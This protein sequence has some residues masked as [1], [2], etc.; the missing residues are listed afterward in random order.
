MSNANNILAYVA[1]KYDG[2]WHKMYDHIKNKVPLEEE[3]VDEYVTEHVSTKF[4]TIVDENYPASLK[5]KV[6]KPPF[7]LFYK[8]D[9]S[10]LNDKSY[11]KLSVVGSRKASRYGVSAVEKIISELSS[12]FIV[13]SGLATGIDAAAHKAALKN[14][15]KTI[16]VLGSGIDNVY[17][18]SNLSLYND[19]LANGGLIVSEYPNKVSPKK[20]NFVFRNRIVAAFGQFLL[21]G[22]AYERSGTQTTLNYALQCGNSVGCVPYSIFANSVC[23]NYIKDGAYLIDGG[24]EIIEIMKGENSSY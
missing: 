20:E 4:M 11:K 22:E 13:I 17:P 14:G 18:E 1:L 16:A 24:K 15:L 7:V 9:I 10:L 23:N 21:I 3:N 8:G 5:R 12:D 2:D 19:I 6:Y